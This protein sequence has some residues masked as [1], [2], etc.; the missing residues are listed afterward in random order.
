MRRALVVVVLVAL[1]APGAAAAHLRSGRS[2]VDFRGSV[3]SFHGPLRTRVYRADLALGLTL[4]GRHR[5]IV[6]GYLGEPFIR[7]DPTGVFVNVAS[8]TAAGMKLASPHP[9]SSRPVWH[10]DWDR[11]I[12]IWHDARVRAAEKSAPGERRAPR[13]RG[14]DRRRSGSHD[15]RLSR[16]LRRA[17]KLRGTRAEEGLTK[18]SLCEVPSSPPTTSAERS[19]AAS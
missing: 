1:A 13:S 7:L 11:P 5:V 12:A 15:P 4:V 18:P 16:L 9:R 3:L 19:S 8:P 10:Q 14:R 6:L 17:R 2:A